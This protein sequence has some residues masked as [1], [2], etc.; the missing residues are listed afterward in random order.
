MQPSQESASFLQCK[1]RGIARCLANVYFF[2]SNITTTR[3]AQQRAWQG[4]DRGLWVMHL[5]SEQFGQALLLASR[6]KAGTAGPPAKQYSV[7]IKGLQ[8][9]E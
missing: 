6:D 3:M 5:R 9:P 1:L 8:H 7:Y 2:I 4:D